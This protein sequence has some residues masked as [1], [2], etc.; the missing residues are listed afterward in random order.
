MLR[1]TDNLDIAPP[2]RSTRTGSSASID[3]KEFLRA[4]SHRTHWH[5]LSIVVEALPMA[6]R[7]CPAL[8]ATESAE[9]SEVSG[10]GPE[11][12][13]NPALALEADHPIQF[14]RRSF[15]RRSAQ[16]VVAILRIG[17][18]GK[19]QSDTT[20]GGADRNFSGQHFPSCRMVQH[21][22]PGLFPKGPADFRQPAIPAQSLSSH[23]RMD[24]WKDVSVVPADGESRE[25]LF[26]DQAFLVMY[27]P[28]ACRTQRF[29]AYV[30]RVPV[31]TS[32][33]HM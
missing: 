26:F 6:D 15:A 14:P 28:S 25:E 8:H 22:P 16:P 30:P 2:L 21:L 18:D 33:W 5:Q 10:F 19:K 1:C 27:I 23:C 29:D 12:T 3:R 31:G 17:S 9:R 11:E 24:G 20:P 7:H 4:T 32:D 13:G